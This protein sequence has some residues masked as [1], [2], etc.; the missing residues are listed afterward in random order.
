MQSSSFGSLSK[1]LR[2]DRSLSQKDLAIPGLSR[3]LISLYECGRVLP[4]YDHIRIIAQRL[5]VSPKVFFG[6]AS[7]AVQNSLCRLMAHA[8]K[9]EE[10]GLFPDA[11][12]LWDDALHRDDVRSDF[13]ALHNVFAVWLSVD[14]SWSVGARF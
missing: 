9:L 14:V 3:S 13:L 1:R 7:D 12:D 4:T 5:G 8:A 10:Q 11:A 2:E 6:G